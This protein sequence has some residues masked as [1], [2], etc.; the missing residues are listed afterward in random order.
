[1]RQM[2]DAKKQD[3]NTIIMVQPI[4][5]LEFGYCITQN[6]LSM[7]MYLY[8]EHSVVK[9]VCWIHAKA[10]KP[11]IRKTKAYIIIIG[12]LVLSGIHNLWSSAGLILMQPIGIGTFRWSAILHIMTVFGTV[13]LEFGLSVGRYLCIGNGLSVISD[14]CLGYMLSRHFHL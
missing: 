10:S 12:L 2:P 5:N 8:I 9:T 13:Q 11:L 4:I 7:Y 6:I 3:D 1:M 14:I